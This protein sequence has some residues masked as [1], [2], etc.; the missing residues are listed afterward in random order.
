MPPAK[1]QVNWGNPQDHSGISTRCK[2]PAI[3]SAAG[4]NRRTLLVNFPNCRS[5]KAED[6]PVSNLV[7]LQGC[8]P[9]CAISGS[10]VYVA[11]STSARRAI[12]ETPFWRAYHRSRYAI[13]FYALLLTLVVMPTASSIGLPTTLI[14]FL[15]G[16]CLLAAVMPT[17]TKRTRLMLFVAI[18]LLIA[19]RV[20]SERGFL[21]VNSGLVLAVVGITGLLAAA[22]AL[23][24]TISAE[25][26]DSETLYAALS[27]YLLAGTFFGQIYWSLEQFWPG[28]I[29]G[30]DKLTELNSVYYSFVTLATLG[31]GDFLPRTD[32]AR[33]VAVFEV[34]GGQLFLAA[35]VARLIGA[36]GG[37]KRGG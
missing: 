17:A 16:A 9:P 1:L 12:R 23:R 25:V 27:T 13:L 4:H 26:V 20:A 15:L 5:P 6:N 2:T 32:I 21:A 30:P 11:K 35:M 10:A 3:W 22:A 34:I 24:F 7:T 18:L 31:Y 36:F 19:A 8:F 28:S 33:G 29:V 14:K 37:A